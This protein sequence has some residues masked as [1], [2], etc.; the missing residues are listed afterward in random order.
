MSGLIHP[1]ERKVVHIFER[2]LLDAI[3]RIR[4]QILGLERRLSGK[5]NSIGNLV[6]TKPVADPVG[7]ARP[8]DN[9]DSGLDHVG[10]S[11]Q[12]RAR[13]YV[14]S[15][16]LLGSKRELT[17]SRLRKL[18]IRSVRAFLVIRTRTNGFDNV[19]VGE[20]GTVCLRRKRV[21][22][23]L[24]DIVHI[25]VTRITD[26]P[27]NVGVADTVGVSTVGVG[28]CLGAFLD[29]WQ[30]LAVVDA[31]QTGAIGRVDELVVGV[32]VAVL[33]V[34][35][36]LDGRVDPAVVDSQCDQVD[37][38]ARH[39]SGFDGGVLLLNVRGEFGAIV[40]AV[41]LEDQLFLL[42]QAQRRD[43]PR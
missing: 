4:R 3:D 7:V 14:V 13:V 42:S 23:W 41:G 30:T 34:R 28:A 17:I 29:R 21:V 9:I 24:A 36:F 10:E 32:V 40:S 33:D 25:K 18:V 20:V 43:L 26:R 5:S 16:A 2:T 37:V 12:E 38:F 27:L 22:S 35:L 11:G 39:R 19:G 15:C 6:V 8:H 31:Q 1:Q